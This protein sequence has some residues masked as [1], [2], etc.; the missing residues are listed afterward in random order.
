MNYTNLS[1]ISKSVCFL[2][3]VIVLSSCNEDKNTSEIK[4]DE[5]NKKIETHKSF[6]EINEFDYK[7][8]LPYLNSEAEVNVKSEIFQ[9]VEKML[10]NINY[11]WE[12]FDKLY[13]D[14][15]TAAEKQNL[16]Y[17]I[18]SQ[19][20]LIG[21]LKSNQ[22]SEV[23]NKKVKQYVNDLVESKY[24]GYCLLFNALEALKSNDP[25]FVK[26]NA[27]LILNYSIND[28]FH[29]DIINNDEMIKNPQTSKYYY[30]IKENY[31]FLERIKNLD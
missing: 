23:Y 13:K 22:E 15:L 18:L 10:V 19:K 28:D 24:L 31:S 4:N 27:N 8:Q 1:S 17:I 16:A 30:K 7:G 20:D 11:S 21:L 14:E 3:F 12:D 9:K 29:N 5:L 2:I 26:E 6:Y 25:K